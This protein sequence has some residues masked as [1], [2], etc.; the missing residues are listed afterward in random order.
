ME[1][2]KNITPADEEKIIKKNDESPDESKNITKKNEL[3][4]YGALVL[5]NAR[6]NH[7]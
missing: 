7:N 6:Y 4:G 5:Q 2:L 1:I 3:G